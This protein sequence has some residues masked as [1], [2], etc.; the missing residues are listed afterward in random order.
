MTRRLA[1][2]VAILAA[3]C[4]GGAAPAPPGPATA[5]DAVAGFLDAVR[6]A[7]I[8]TMAEFWGDERGA[9]AA[10]MAP[11]ELDKRLAVVQR[12]LDHTAYRVVEGPVP[13]RGDPKRVSFRVELRRG[14]CVQVQPIDLV[15]ARQG[16]WVIQDVHLEAARS[17]TTACSPAPPGTGR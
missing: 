5:A 2:H 10:W 8:K 11:D 13:V 6:L 1:V 9:A 7:D 12:Y 3:A 15:R 17:P 14:D 4:G 16:G